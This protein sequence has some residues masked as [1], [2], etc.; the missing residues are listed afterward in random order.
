MRMTLLL[1]CLPGLAIAGTGRGQVK[2]GATKPVVY[3]ASDEKLT[4]KVQLSDEMAAK[5]IEVIGRESMPF[6]RRILANP[7]GY[8]VVQNKAYSLYGNFITSD[9]SKGDSWI[10]PVFSRF[11]EELNRIKEDLA[12]LKDFKP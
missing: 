12:P 7:R 9:P 5:V 11:W 3:Y 4:E 10:D 2:G 8:F 6:E 1:V